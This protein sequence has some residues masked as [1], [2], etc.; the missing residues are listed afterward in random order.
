MSI[1][2]AHEASSL[3]TS[4]NE[5][6]SMLL[7]PKCQVLYPLESYLS[8]NGAQFTRF[9]ELCRI[10]LAEQRDSKRRRENGFHGIESGSWDELLEFL[11]ELYLYLSTFVFGAN[12]S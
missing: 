6:E 3:S 10:S 4:S 2:L 1:L 11:T 5:T 12:T 7:C 9:C 8:V